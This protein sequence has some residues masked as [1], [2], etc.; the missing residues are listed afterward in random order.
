MLRA[1]DAVRNTL[2][3]NKRSLMVTAAAI[4]LGAIIMYLFYVKIS[5]ATD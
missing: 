3:T 2:N 5:E 1:Q 4:A